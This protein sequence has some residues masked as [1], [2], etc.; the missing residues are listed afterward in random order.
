MTFFFWFKGGRAFMNLEEKFLSVYIMPLCIK[1]IKNEM[2]EL[3]YKT[4]TCCMHKL[5]CNKCD[6]SHRD[7]KYVVAGS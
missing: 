5:S 7:Q 2:Y 6:L 4:L 1:M 3:L